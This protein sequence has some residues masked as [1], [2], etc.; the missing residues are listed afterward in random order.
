[1]SGASHRLGRV[2]SFAWAYRLAKAGIGAQR[3]SRTFVETYIE[4]APGMRILDLGCGPADVLEDL[5]GVDYVGVDLSGAYIEAARAR[6]GGRGRF[7]CGDVGQLP[8]D[9][10]GPYDRVLA[11]GLLHHLE[12]TECLALLARAASLLAPGG[13]LVTLDGCYRDGQSPLARF[14]LGRDRGRRVRTAEGYL[15]L[16]R[17]AF[18]AVESHLRED[19]LRIPYTHLI[20]RGRKPSTS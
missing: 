20:L 19:L 1:M 7:L 3:A 10:A 18:P 17:L 5:E 11:L 14:F 8:A 6:F 4:P 9:L 13:L 16:A 12:D 2:L 15:A